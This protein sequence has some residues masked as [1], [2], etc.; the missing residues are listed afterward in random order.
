[1]MIRS[2][3]I[4]KHARGQNCTLRLDGCR[5]D[6]DTVVFAHI[7]S[8][9]AGK[10]MGVKA[11]DFLGCFACHHC[12]T[13]LDSQKGRSALSADLL[14]ALCE[15]WVV[16]VFDDIIDV[17]QDKPKPQR[18]RKPKA[19]SGPSRPIPTRTNPWPAKGTQSIQSRPFPKRAK[20][21]S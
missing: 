9:M 3:A 20:E 12:H 14:R 5:N 4:L 17:R 10:G 1:M 16:L 19:K 11:H 8:G 15:T 18:D 13:L 2:K 21:K 6:R 7:N